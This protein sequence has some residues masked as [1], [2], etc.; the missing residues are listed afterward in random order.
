VRNSTP[1]RSIKAGI[2]EFEPERILPIDAAAHGIG[3]LPIG[4]PFS[5]L[6]DGDQGQTPRGFCWLSGVRKQVREAFVLVNRA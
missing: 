1:H 4:K 3:G 5:K 2:A 6:H